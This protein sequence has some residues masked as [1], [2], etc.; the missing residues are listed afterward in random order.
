MP[1]KE[2]VCLPLKSSPLRRVKELRDTDAQCQ[3]QFQLTEQGSGWEG[4]FESSANRIS[5]LITFLCDAL[6]LL[7]GITLLTEQV[8]TWEYKPFASCWRHSPPACPYGCLMKKRLTAHLSDKC[9][10]VGI[11]TLGHY[12]LLI[13]KSFPSTPRM[14]LGPVPIVV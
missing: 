7:E 1:V 9:L 14:S 8:L 10:V 2:A 12:F 13:L 5:P 3:F 6:F 4:I 11:P